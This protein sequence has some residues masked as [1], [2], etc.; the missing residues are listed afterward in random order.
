[1]SA[2]DDVKKSNTKSYQQIL[3][4]ILN[5]DLPVEPPIIHINEKDRAKIATKDFVK[6][7][8]SQKPVIGLNVGVG[9]KWPSKG[10]V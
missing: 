3:Y 9:T 7:M 4:E 8:T 6:N 10:G 2:F 1:M 5:L